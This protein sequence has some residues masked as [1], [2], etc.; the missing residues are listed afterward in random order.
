[1]LYRRLLLAFL[2][3]ASASTLPSCADHAQPIRGS[4]D[5]VDPPYGWAAYC[6][7]HPEDEGCR[8]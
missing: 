3:A 1:M 4:G 6:D 7:R 8:T 5:E 2:V